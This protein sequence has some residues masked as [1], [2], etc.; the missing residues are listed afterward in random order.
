MIDEW[1]GKDWLEEVG[2]NILGSRDLEPYVPTK[3][4]IKDV[5]RDFYYEADDDD[6]THMA[7]HQARETP[8]KREK[9]RERYDW[10]IIDWLCEWYG[11][12]SEMMTLEVSKP[13]MKDYLMFFTI[14]GPLDVFRTKNTSFHACITY[15]KKL[16]RGRKHVNRLQEPTKA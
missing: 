7:V 15:L 1:N 11:Y 16:E 10:D 12:W 8:E 13:T 14:R 2:I 5:W 4:E 3:Q 9:L 6:M